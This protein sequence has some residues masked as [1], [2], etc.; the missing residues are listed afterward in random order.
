ME[1]DIAAF[2][3]RLHAEADALTE[4]AARSLSERAPVQLDQQSVGRL[5]RMDALQ[6]QAMAVAEQDRRDVRLQ[7]VRAALARIEDG[8]FGDC[9]TCDEPIEA[10]RLSADPTVPNCIGCARGG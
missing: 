2:R 8:T 6:V 1:P 5:S 10:K 4:T 3:A 9:L 7:R